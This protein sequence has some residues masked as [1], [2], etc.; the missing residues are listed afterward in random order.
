MLPQGNMINRSP[1]LPFRERWEVP[2]EQSFSAWSDY[3]ECIGCRYDLNKMIHQRSRDALVSGLS[4]DFSNDLSSQAQQDS[5]AGSGCPTP[6]SW[7]EVL[8]AVRAERQTCSVEHG[9]VSLSA[10]MF[11]RGEP[12]YLL[13]GFV[14]DHE[15]Y[16][17]TSW[18]LRE[19]CC[20]V[21][22]DP[23]R[24]KSVSRDVLEQCGQALLALAD[25]LGHRVF[26]LH[27]TSLGSLI[28]LRAMLD[29]PTR[30]SAASLHC[31]F[32]GWKLTM[33]ER[34]L[35]ALG[36]RSTRTLGGVK[37]AVRLQTTNHQCWFPPYDGSRWDYYLQN[38]AATPLADVSRGA[39]LANS[40]DLHAE[41]GRILTPILLV[42][43][44]GD[45]RVSA[46][47]QAALA[48]KLQNTQTDSLDNCGRLPHV[49]HPHRLVKSF[50][51]FWESIT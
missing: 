30:V 51:A 13:P 18:L 33:L 11:G 20:C 50:K 35:A 47:A 45:G 27:A 29:G 9:T 48:A 22:L 1:G 14:G 16:V 49:T 28:A 39:L 4:T 40:V 32:A 44:E 38:I 6:L 24:I 43:C 21:M 8:Q 46:A 41:L 42:N 5:A 19:E 34:W 37:S 31:G 26:R 10:A 23:P 2:T 25:Q 15:L 17:L 3:E 36:R 7:Q 12:L